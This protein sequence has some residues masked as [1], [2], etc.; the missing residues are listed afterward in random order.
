YLADPQLPF[1]SWLRSITE[2]QLL[3]AHRHHLGT[4]MRAAGREAPSRNGGSAAARTGLAADL[5]GR[6]PTPSRAAVQQEKHELVHQ[7]WASM[8]PHDREVLILR[9]YEMLTNEQ[10]AQV[11]GITK[12]AASNRYIRALQRLKETLPRASEFADGL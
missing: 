9:H 5:I 10:I 12:S 11:L 8:D 4:Q 2:K 6:E 7:A 3:A 1:H